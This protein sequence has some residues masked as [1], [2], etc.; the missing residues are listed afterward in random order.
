MT[1]NPSLSD[2]ESE[3]ESESSEAAKPAA[4][5]PQEDDFTS[6]YMR[7]LAA[8]MGDDL[9]K[10]REASDFTARSLPMLIHALRQGESAFSAEERG[11][12]VVGARS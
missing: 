7:R 1:V 8:E 3:S 12:V 9:D 10:V 6:I 11:R 4:K 5:N 2:P